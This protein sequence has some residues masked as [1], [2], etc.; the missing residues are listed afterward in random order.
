MAVNVAWERTGGV[1]IGQVAGRVDSSNAAEL[2]SALDAQVSAGDNAL[3][4]DFENLAFISSAGLRVGLAAAKQL[5]E[6]SKK[7]GV[8]TLSSSVREVIEVSGFG[9]VISV[10]ES[11]SEA[12][13]ALGSG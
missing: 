1:L 3:L 12:L 10:Y 11:R 4:L 9:Q 8:C 13:A 7:F 6:E 5:G 2:Q